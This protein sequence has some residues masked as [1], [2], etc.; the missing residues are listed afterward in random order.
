MLKP[1]LSRVGVGHLDW[2][3]ALTNNKQILTYNPEG[4]V[5]FWRPDG[6]LLHES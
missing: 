1:W 6:E 2:R 4:E 3:A 5:I